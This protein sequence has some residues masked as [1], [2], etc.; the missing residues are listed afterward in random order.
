[1]ITVDKQKKG[2][3]F[4]LDQASVSLMGTP[5]LQGSSWKVRKNEHWLVTGDNGSGKTTLLRAIAGQLPIC[6]GRFSTRFKRPIS[7]AVATVSMDLERRILENEDAGDSGRY[8]S[9]SLSE[10]TRVYD[11]IFDG[12]DATDTPPALSM[13]AHLSNRHLRSLSTGEMKMV[14]MARAIISKPEILI[15]DEPFEGLDPKASKNLSELLETI[16]LSSIS[17]IV[18]THRFDFLPAIFTHRIHLKDL[19]IKSTGPINR[20]LFKADPTKKE[21]LTF[22]GKKLQNKPEP[23]LAQT[24]VKFEDVTIRYGKVKALSHLSWE[25]KQGEN[26][27][28][29]GANG[30]GKSTL[31]GLIYGDN[32][33]AYANR[34]FIFGKRRGTGESIWEI[35]KRM[36][37]VSNRLQ[38][39]FPGNI[40][41]LS[42]VISGF[43]DSS[44]LFRTASSLQKERAEASLLMLGIGSWGD[45]SFNSLS[46]GQQRIVL[47]ARALVKEPEILILDELCSG[48]D[49]TNRK[50]IL[51]VIDRLGHSRKRSMVYIS[52]HND[53]IPPCMDH[54]L[55]LQVVTI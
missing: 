19:T 15:L 22:P 14:M 39:G 30:S 1:V 4:L 2:Q 11:F 5:V 10:G 16:A 29:Q 25:L 38:L 40:S 31:A 35:K 20:E 33:Q 46:T 12:K 49:Q 9:G 23:E 6:E 37:F 44:G 43:F 48:L 55:K 13:V 50:E 17:L 41:V 26:W 21:I 45:K 8:F 27:L 47:V 51:Q 36:G 54:L 28:V 3:L 24:L 53:E 32:P 34:I 42:T 52:H 7:K 18:S